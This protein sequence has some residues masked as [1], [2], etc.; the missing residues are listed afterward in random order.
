MGAE[1]PA[2][3]QGSDE[4]C[5]ETADVDEDVEDLETGVAFGG[6][7][8]IVVELAHDCLE[9]AFEQAVAEGYEE[10]GEAGER[11]EPGDVVG[12]GEDGDGEDHVADGHDDEAVDDGPL[13]VLGFVGDGTAYEAEQVDAGVEERVDKSAGLLGESEF[14]TEEEDQDGVHDV[15]AESLAHVAESSR[16]KAFGLVFEHNGLIKGKFGY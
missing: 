5:H 15:V 10:E 12:G 3:E 9:V 6:V 14:R 13:V 16:N 11:Q 4:G 8:G 1:P 2:A 7:F